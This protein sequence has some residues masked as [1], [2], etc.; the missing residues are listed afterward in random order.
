RVVMVSCDP[1]TAMRDLVILR[2]AGF[3]LQRVQ[4]V[5]MFP[6]TAHV[7]VVYLLERES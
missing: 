7:E 6:G 4:P 5:D 3:A 1:A 2:D